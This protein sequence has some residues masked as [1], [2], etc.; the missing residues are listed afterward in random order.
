[1]FRGYLRLLVFAFGLLVGVQV[2]GFVADYAKRVDA[3]RAESEQSLLGFRET[4]AKFFNGDL[5]ALVAHYRASTD[6]VMRSDADSVEHLVS[7]YTLLEAEWLAMQG[8]W[9]AQIWHLS[10]DADQ[11]LLQETYD[12]YTYQVL[13]APQAIFWGLGV[14]LVLA[15]LA[16]LLALGVGWTVGI[17]RKHKT[18]AY[19][20]RHWR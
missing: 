12:A 6:E 18:I 20:K 19:E 2:P 5:N 14:G 11:A 7:R 8:P 17:G 3:H 10:T 9:Y 1:M 15:W 13:L 4:A 16:E